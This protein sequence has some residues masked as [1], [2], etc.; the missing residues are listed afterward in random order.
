MTIVV[1][2]EAGVPGRASVSWVGAVGE[3]GRFDSSFSSE[4]RA[5]YIFQFPSSAALQDY[6][7]KMTS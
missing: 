3:L 1:K 6:C 2:S 5:L 4:R 7:P